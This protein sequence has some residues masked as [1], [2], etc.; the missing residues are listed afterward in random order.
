MY[1][2]HEIE[3]EP[4]TNSISIVRHTEVGPTKVWVRRSKLRVVDRDNP[5][6]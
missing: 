4:L 6:T 5:Y 3:F 1:F 2:A